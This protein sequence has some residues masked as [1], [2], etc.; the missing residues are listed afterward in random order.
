MKIIL[1]GIFLVILYFLL[2]LPKVSNYKNVHLKSQAN[3]TNLCS[4]CQLLARKGFGQRDTEEMAQDYTNACGDASNTGFAIG[5]MNSDVYQDPLEQ[6]GYV[7][8]R[9]GNAMPS[10]PP[11]EGGY[12]ETPIACGY[13]G[14]CPSGYNILCRHYDAQPGQPQP[15]CF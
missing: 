11:Q 5:V 1:F 12:C 14:S 3:P 8:D 15:A 10:L 4:T 7:S 2:T 9:Y 6:Q 13:D